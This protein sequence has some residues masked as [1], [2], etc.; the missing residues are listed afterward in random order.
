[1]T[2]NQGK[3]L[4]LQTLSWTWGAVGCLTPTSG[5]LCPALLAPLCPYHP[6]HITYTPVTPMGTESAEARAQ[7]IQE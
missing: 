3:G 1:M 4:A 6:C 5:E 2:L 7:Q